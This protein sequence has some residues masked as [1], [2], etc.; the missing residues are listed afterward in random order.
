MLKRQHTQCRLRPRPWNQH[1]R[2]RQRQHQGMRFQHHGQGCQHAQHHDRRQNQD[3]AGAGSTTLILLCE[4]FAVSNG[5]HHA[6][7]QGGSGSAQ[8]IRFSNIRVTEVQ[9]PI[10]IDQFYC[11]KSSCKNQTSAVALSGI[12]YENIKGTYTVKPVHFA[13]SD[14]SPC[15][16][17]SLTG[18]ELKPLQEQYHMYQPFCWQTFGELYTPT[19]PPIVC[20]QNGKPEGNRILSD[21]DVC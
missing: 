17:I 16:D 10:V 13:C 20:L 15:S 6:S 9:T 3:L 4:H 18:V 5:C 12:A 19:I 11:D 14:T 1:R 21:R 8:S 7:S 2:P